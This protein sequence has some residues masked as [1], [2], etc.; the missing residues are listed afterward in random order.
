MGLII[1]EW[2]AE[3]EVFRV[4]ERK[5]VSSVRCGMLMSG[6]RCVFILVGAK[7]AI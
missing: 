4:A 2:A 3:G 7:V 6:H 1:S 5:E